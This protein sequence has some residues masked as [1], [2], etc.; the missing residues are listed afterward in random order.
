MRIRKFPADLHK[1][2]GNQAKS[3]AFQARDNL[4]NQGTLDTI[5]FD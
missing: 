3:A 2:R 1:L 4:P 5:R